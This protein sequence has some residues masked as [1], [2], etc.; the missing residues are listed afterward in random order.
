MAPEQAAGEPRVDARTDVYALGAVLHEMLAGE[1]P[2][3]A[4]S[5]QAVLRRVM[6]EPPMALATR[7]ADVPPSLDAAVRRALA[8]RPDERFPS[9]AAFA[10]ALAV[11]L[12]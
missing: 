3:A 8:K 4:A 12:A 2:F 7:R 5:Q 9:A 1:S 10:A 11:P 6:H